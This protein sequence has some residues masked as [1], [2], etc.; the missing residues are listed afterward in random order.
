MGFAIKDSIEIA[1]I[2]KNNINT[3]IIDYIKSIIKET[4]A[5]K[6]KLTNRNDYYIIFRLKLKDYL[7]YL[8]TNRIIQH[9]HIVFINVNM[10]KFKYVYINDA[11]L[12]IIKYNF[13][14][15]KLNNILK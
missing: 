14:K 9:Y 4:D 6:S 13:R 1:K 3:I 11:Q 15:E 5:F 7:D 12:S 8:L 2:N 10:I